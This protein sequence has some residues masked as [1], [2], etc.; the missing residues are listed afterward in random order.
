M[1]PLLDDLAAVRVEQTALARRASRLLDL[2]SHPQVV[3][4]LVAYRHGVRCED[5][6]DVLRCAE[7][8]DQR[9]P[10]LAAYT[11]L[12]YEREEGTCSPVGV[13]IGG[14]LHTMNELAARFPGVDI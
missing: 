1:N 6:H 10:L 11:A 9:T 14:L 13:S 12:L 4:V 3:P 8:D 5:E 7:N 2:L